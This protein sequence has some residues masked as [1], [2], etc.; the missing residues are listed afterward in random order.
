MPKLFGVAFIL[1]FLFAGISSVVAQTDQ[2]G[3]TTANV[4]FQTL[5]DITPSQYVRTILNS[6]LGIAG[7]A[8]LIFL[9]IGGIRWVTSGG[10]KDV[11]EKARKIIA[12]ALLGLILVFSIYAIFFAV[13]TFFGIDPIRIIL[14]PLG[15]NASGGGGG[16][17]PG[18]GP[19]PN[20]T[21]NPDPQPTPS[22]QG[23]P[24]P[25]NTEPMQCAS[26]GQIGLGDD[27][28]CHSCTS[29]GW[30]DPTGSTSCPPITCSYA[31]P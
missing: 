15:Q 5:Q 25:C 10:D 13:R 12:N 30:S 6:L 22:T 20:P 14:S 23:G 28:Q 16:G 8:S 3:I 27:G 24:C 9:L 31:C 17:G 26:L 11:A 1:T 18:P 7:V 29:S 4:N 21:S 19:G 2:V